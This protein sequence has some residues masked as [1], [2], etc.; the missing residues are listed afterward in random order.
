MEAEYWHNAWTEDRIGFH[1]P[2]VNKRL[3][4]WWPALE[5][6][7]GT[8][9]LVPLCG[10]SIDMLWLHRRGYPV[11]GV[12][13]SSKASRAFFTENELPF[14]VAQ[15][16]DFE[17]FTGTG[18]ATGLQVLAG[19]FFALTPSHTRQCVGFYDRASLIAM[20][21]AM[22]SEYALQLGR[23]LPA[24]SR[25]LLSRFHSIRTR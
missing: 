23:I 5:H 24:G 17:V 18:S 19:D 6:P 15:Q 7:P 3:Q 9:V 8:P 1:Q 10:K 11:L 14:D 16:G 20:N 12:E 25:G 13:L 2:D 4:K 21:P 22:Q